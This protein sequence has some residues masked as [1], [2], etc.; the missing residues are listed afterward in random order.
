MLS[1]PHP[2]GGP[3]DLRITARPLCGFETLEGSSK[4]W[5]DYLGFRI[6]GAREAGG[7][8]AGLEL[9]ESATSQHARD[10]REGMIPA[11]PTPA[12]RTSSRTGRDDLA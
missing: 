6:A 11:A 12:A 10:R 5:T 8:A 4:A 9:E 7:A 2:T 3:G 1:A